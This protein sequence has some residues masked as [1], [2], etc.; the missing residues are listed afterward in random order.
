MENITEKEI[1]LKNENDSLKE[2]LAHLKTLVEMRVIQCASIEK[3][4]HE[5][6]SRIEFLKGQIEAYQYMMNCRR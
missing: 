3:Q 5:L 6:K 2:E 1:S 4:N